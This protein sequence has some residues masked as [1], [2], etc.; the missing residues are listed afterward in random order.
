MLDFVSRH[1]SEYRSTY[2]NITSASIG[3]IQRALLA[4]DSEGADLFFG[5]PAFDVLDLLQTEG[6][7]GIMNVLAADK[8]MLKPKL[9]STFLLWMM[10]DLYEKLPEV[11]DLDYPKLV[12]FFDEAHMLFEGTSNAMVSKIE[13]IIRLIRSKGVGIYFVTQYP[14][15]VPE[16]VLGQLAN[17]VEHALRSYTPKDQKAVRAAAESF[18]TNP[19]F[20][21]ATAISEL[22]TGEALVSFLDEKGAP[23]IVERAKILFPLSQIGAITEGQRLDAIKQS[24]L[25]GKY[26]KMV[27]RESA[28]EVL[29]KQAEEQVE[30]EEKGKGK[31]EKAKKKT[32]KRGV[33][34]K[35]LKAVVTA[36]TASVA[37]NLGTIVSNSVTGTKSKTSTKDAAG[38][39]VKNATSAATRTITR[40][41]TRGVLGNL[42]K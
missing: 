4:L 15:D 28:F 31:A 19:A 38:R 30:E 29:L 25:Y 1:A 11:G 8:L 21:T 10:S 9:Y 13:Q 42:V 34:A 26:D 35:V 3:S 18:R 37:T 22:G 14:T 33:A 20:D 7:K 2:G 16:S 5:E 27:D 17:K 40:E 32:A 6:G 39:A 23:N 36:L 41:L 12:F 24:R